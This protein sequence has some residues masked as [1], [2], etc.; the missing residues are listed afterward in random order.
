MPPPPEGQPA[1]CDGR[2]D[3]A[4]NH[5]VPMGYAA[6]DVRSAVEA[7]LEVANAA[8]SLVPSSSYIAPVEISI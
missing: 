4:I 3:A 8:P 2:I 7:L 6:H 1:K 5:F